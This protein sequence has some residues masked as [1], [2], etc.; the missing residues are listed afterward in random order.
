MFNVKTKQKL[1][2]LGDINNQ[3]MVKTSKHNLF[4]S[5]NQSMNTFHK[6]SKHIN[7]SYNTDKSG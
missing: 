5:C 1:K 3:T 7:Q 2:K 6:L 4:F